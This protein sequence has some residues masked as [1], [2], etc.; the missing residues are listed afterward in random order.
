MSNL[1][2]TNLN[3]TNLNKTN[4]NKINIINTDINN[5][6]KTNLNKINIINTDI[7]NLNK[8]N[9]NKINIGR[10]TKYE[11]YLYVKYYPIYLNN[12]KILSTIIKTR[13]P[14]QIRSHHQKELK[15]ATQVA[16]IL[17]QLKNY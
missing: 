9:L 3:K 2:K 4:L 14:I 11:N 12:W 10:W 5:L 8:T 7:N 1:N 13:T 16:K 15:S 17:L 6:N